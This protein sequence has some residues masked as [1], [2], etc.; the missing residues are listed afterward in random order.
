MFERQMEIMRSVVERDASGAIA[1]LEPPGS[2]PYI[3]PCR[4]R[5]RWAI[6]K[7]REQLAE[8]RAKAK[9]TETVYLLSG[10]LPAQTLD[11]MTAEQAGRQDHRVE[12]RE[13]RAQVQ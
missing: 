13:A 4:G 8:A 3:G 5:P 1:G 2:V 9:P 6:D 10:L 7:L 12:T 11:A